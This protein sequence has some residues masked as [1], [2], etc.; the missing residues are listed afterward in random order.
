MAVLWSKKSAFWLAL[1]GL[2]IAALVLWL[3]QRTE[4][5]NARV[6]AEIKTNPQGDRAARTMIVTLADGRIYPVNYLREGDRVFMGIDGRWWRV[7]QG[8]GQ[9]V[10]MLIKN[11]RL[12]GHGRVVLDNQEYVDQ[13]FARLR[14]KA[15]SWLPA[16]LNG[17]LV[18]IE[19]AA[20][21]GPS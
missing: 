5:T 14:P 1:F 2:G 11:Q 6:M 19:L 16:W 18:V 7:F 10:D 21:Q 20:Q 17:K 3:P 13:V 8:Q 12:S 15:P 9:S 4:Q